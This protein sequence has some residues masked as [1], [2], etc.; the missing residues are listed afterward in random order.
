MSSHKMKMWD[1]F[2]TH[3]TGGGGGRPLG[4]ECSSARVCE[5][6]AVVIAAAA[7]VAFLVV[8]VLHT[9][10]TTIIIS[11]AAPPVTSAPASAMPT[12]KDFFLSLRIAPQTAPAAAAFCQFNS[13]AADF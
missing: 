7:A 9:A 5:S 6:A 12:E 13:D 2:D 3:V 10:S 8:A 4:T 1:D 11:D